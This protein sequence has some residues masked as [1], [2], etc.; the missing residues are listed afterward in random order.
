MLTTYAIVPNVRP[1][2]ARDALAEFLGDEGVTDAEVTL[3]AAVSGGNCYAITAPDTTDNRA[4]LTRLFGEFNLQAP[5]DTAGVRSV[6]VAS[7]R[8]R[9]A[10]LPHFDARGSEGRFAKENPPPDWAR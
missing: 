2:L 6:G 5:Q 9:F 8:Q 3:F 1:D 4:T 10:D 7:A